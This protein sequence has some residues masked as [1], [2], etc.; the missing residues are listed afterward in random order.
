MNH[1][2]KQLKKKL[3][4][5]IVICFSYIF[6]DFTDAFL[7]N[8]KAFFSNINKILR[9]FILQK[10]APISRGVFILLIA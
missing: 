8:T 9:L 6:I 2:N 10:N 4:T 5:I 1:L 3:A 7:L